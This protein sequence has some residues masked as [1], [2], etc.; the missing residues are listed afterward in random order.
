MADAIA[1]SK[2]RR[3]LLDTGEAPL[4]LEE[5]FWLGTAGGGAFFAAAGFGPSGSFREGC[6]LDALIIDDS[7]LAAPFAL[8]I[9]D[10]LERVVYLSEDRHIAGKYVRGV[11][12][13]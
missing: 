7:E 11:K 2:L 8:S 3:A 13:R 6:D 12:V 1:V 5:A 10:R 4:T 9:R